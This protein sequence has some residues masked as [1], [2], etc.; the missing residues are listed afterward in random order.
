MVPSTPHTGDGPATSSQHTH[1]TDTSFPTLMADATHPHTT[2]TPQTPNSPLTPSPSDEATQSDLN[3]DMIR[4]CE[5]AALFARLRR[6]RGLFHSSCA[7]NLFFHERHCL[8]PSSLIDVYLIWYVAG[9]PAGS[10]T[11]RY[12]GTTPRCLHRGLPTRRSDIGGPCTAWV[13]TL[14]ASRDSNP[15]TAVSSP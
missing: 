6:R 7:L 10:R 15:L 2:D 8:N 11:W 12:S 9:F 3:T 14:W 1:N 4:L 13:A 5:T